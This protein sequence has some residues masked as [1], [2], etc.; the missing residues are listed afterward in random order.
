MVNQE[1]HHHMRHNKCLK[2]MFKQSI[3]R[4]DDAMSV[5]YIWF[6]ADIAHGGAT[7]TRHLVTAILL[8]ELG[9]TAVT[10]PH[11]CL[12]HLLFTVMRTDTG[13]VIG[14]TR[15]VSSYNPDDRAILIRTGLNC[16]LLYLNSIQKRSI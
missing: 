14:N 5:S 10:H 16:L 7:S 9:L 8:R 15:S 13:M 6:P 2:G 1:Y 11:L 12:R 4:Q 3:L